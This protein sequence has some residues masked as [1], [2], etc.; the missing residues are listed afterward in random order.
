[1][2]V[3]C[4]ISFTIAILVLPVGE[5]PATG[6]NR[7]ALLPLTSGASLVL[8][9]PFFSD[10]GVST[11]YLVNFQVDVSQQVNLGNF[12][13]GTS[14]VE[15]RGLFNGWA[16]SVTPLTNDTV[17][18]VPGEPGHPIW[19]GSYLVTNSPNGAEAY[20]YVIQAR[21][22]LGFSQRR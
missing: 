11:N 20:K 14:T 17:T 7:A 3:S 9:T 19:Y 15:V 10:A 6:Q 13:P 18:T 1:M 5:N 2:V 4:N 21:H 22:A 12:I 8:P 16:G